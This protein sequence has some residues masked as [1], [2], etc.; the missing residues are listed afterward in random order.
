[1]RGKIFHYTFLTGISIL[2]LCVT[3]FS[4]VLYQYYERQIFNSLSAEAAYVSQGLT[5][6]GEDYFSDFSSPDRVTWVAAD[7]RVLYDSAAQA[8]TMENHLNRE[9]IREALETGS[10]QS[11]HFSDTMMQKTLYYAKLLS[12]GT[13]LRISCTQRTVGAVLLRM[14]GPI[15]WAVGLVVVLSGLLAYGLARQITRPINTMDLDVPEIRP[16]Y[17]ELQPLALR[18]QEQNRT[19]CRQMEELSLRQRE[20]SAITENMGEGFLLLD[21]KKNILSGNHSAHQ[22]LRVQDAKNIKEAKCDAVFCQAVDHA[23]AGER[24]EALLTEG[25]ASWQLI[26]SPVQAEGQVTGAVVILVDVT[27]REQRETLRRE[28]SA[29]VSHELKTPLTSI[30]GFAELMKEGLVPPE[31]IPEFSG[32]I[33]RETLRLIDLVNDI[34]NLS[35]L[36]EAAEPFEKER[37]D[38]YALCG[39][40]LQG[41][42]P[43][44]DKK[45]VSLRLAGE[46]LSING[47]P[48]ILQEMIF[49][50][51][52]NAIKYNRE[53]GS[54]T[55]SLELQASET[56]L[57]VA[58]TGVGIPYAAQNRVFERF[59]RVDKSHSRA[60]GGTGLG[61]SIVK[62]GA[63]YHAARIE[64][65]STPG[66]G[67]VITLIFP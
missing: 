34:I 37:V 58:D 16:A 56:R 59:Y 15:T 45:Q 14:A 21:Q 38:L 60:V 61:L 52:D 35:R 47:V 33:W 12:D 49:N 46:H 4:V 26:V 13:V 39:S 18:L 62:H 42:Q 6:L 25:G 67:T 3:L 30:S 1:M 63:Q 9:E 65:H 19:I 5:V 29:N 54:V 44:A 23:L 2:V 57:S 8:S 31:K 28:F 7:G 36:D 17:P 24:A 55:V 20:F 27:E 43:Q 11:T 22:L 10:G 66:V 40:V 50:L 32:D 53:G 51:C 48:Q 41:L 64:L